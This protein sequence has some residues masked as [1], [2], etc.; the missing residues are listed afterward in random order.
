M[1]T[2]LEAAKEVLKTAHAWLGDLSAKKAAEVAW[3]NGDEVEFLSALGQLQASVHITELVETASLKEIPEDLVKG[4]AIPETER[5]ICDELYIKDALKLLGEHGIDGFA[6]VV[7]ERVSHL[8]K[9]LCYYG[10]ARA[11]AEA[12]KEDGGAGK[13]M[14]WFA[15]LP[16]DKTDDLIERLDETIHELFATQASAVNNAGIEEQVKCVFEQCGNKAWRVLG[17]TWDEWEF[18]VEP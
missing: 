7:Q 3:A 14:K 9:V 15:A 8:I 1:R 12:K 11:A 10:E 13:V 5:V 17:E 18:E 4:L 6:G 16:P 2:L